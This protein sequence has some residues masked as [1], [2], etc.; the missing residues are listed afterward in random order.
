MKIKKCVILTAGYG[1]RMLPITKTVSKEML[2]LIDKPAIFY[3]VKEAYLSGIKEIIFVVSKNN[4]KLLKSFFSYNQELMNEIKDNKEKKHLLAEVNDII[5][6]MK[7]TYVIQKERGTYGALWSARKYLKSEPFALLYGDDLII[8]Q[9]P[10]LKQLIAEYEKT[11]DIIIGARTLNDKDLP[12]FGMIKYKEN[13]ILDTICYL[14]ENGRSN[15][16]IQ[17]RFI[18]TPD[19]FLLKNQLVYHNGELQ[20]P[21]A[22]LLLDR[23]KRIILYEGKY[24]NIGNKLEYVKAI[25]HEALENKNMKDEIKEFIYKLEK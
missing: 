7:F 16:V 12:K 14:Q 21:T 6:H 2:P 20:L 25:I 5:K 3:Q 23:N 4:I 9:I 10:V 17:G 11:N 24:F 18:L 19:V 1:T 22:L 15:D 8:G 13:N